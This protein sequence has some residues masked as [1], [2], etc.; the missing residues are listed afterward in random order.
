MKS[1]IL[2]SEWYCYASAALTASI[3]FILQFDWPAFDLGCIELAR[4]ADSQKVI[5]WGRRCQRWMN[6]NQWA[7][8]KEEWN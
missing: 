4:S 1:P 3:D 6:Y 7:E 2:T 5:T 8:G